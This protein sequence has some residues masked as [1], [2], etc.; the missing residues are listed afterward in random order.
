VDAIQ[1][2]STSGETMGSLGAKVATSISLVLPMFNESPCVDETLSRAVAILQRRFA[3]FEVVVADD[4]STDGSADQVAEWAR[5]DHRIKLVRLL[6]NQRFGG[7]L[8]AGL[9][10]TQNELLFYTDFDLPID[11]NVLPRLLDDF[12]AADI[13]TGY[14]AVEAKHVNWRQRVVSFG[15]NFL[16]RSLF[17]LRL[18]DI[19][20]GFKAIRRSCWSRLALRSCSPFVDAE[21]FIQA[22]RLGFRIKQVPVPFEQRRLGTSRIRRLDVIGATMLDMLRLR[23]AARPPAD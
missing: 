2:R 1:T 13:L 5:R 22:Q 8:R 17:G 12:A 19:N 6:R 7:A 10:A 4:G 3:D 11:L 20:F 15:Y 21:L 16:V 9:G 23:L 14:S 18:R